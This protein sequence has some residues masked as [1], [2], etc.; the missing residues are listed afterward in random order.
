MRQNYLGIEIYE[1]L[2]QGW[3]AKLKSDQHDAGADIAVLA[4]IAMP[5]EIKNFGPYEGVW[6]TDFASAMGLAAALRMGL[7]NAVREKV[8]AAMSLTCCR[9]STSTA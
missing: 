1:S 9:L 7:I 3:V 4:T 6:V 5:K 2:R 8:L